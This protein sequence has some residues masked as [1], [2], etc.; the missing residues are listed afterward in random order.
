MCIISYQFKQDLT[1]YIGEIKARSGRGSLTDSR[2]QLFN[3][4]DWTCHK[5]K[6]VLRKR[7]AKELIFRN[8]PRCQLHT[9]VRVVS[10]TYASLEI[11]EQQFFGTSQNSCFNYLARSFFTYFCK[12]LRLSCRIC[13][14]SVLRWCLP[15]LKPF[16]K[17]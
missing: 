12:T 6:K 16:C 9:W 3:G 10:T 17:K 5:F 1:I 13:C 2:S 4:Q 7:S 8:V 14:S 11:Q 15:F